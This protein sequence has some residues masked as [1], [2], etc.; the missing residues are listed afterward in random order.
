[1]IV[2]ERSPAGAC[3]RCNESGELAVGSMGSLGSARCPSVVCVVL[4]RIREGI[5]SSDHPGTS[6]GSDE[7]TDVDSAELR[8][9]IK[10]LEVEIYGPDRSDDLF[11]SEEV[12]VNLKQIV[13]FL[14][15][16]HRRRTSEMSNTQSLPL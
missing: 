9:R 13:V 4:Q 7:S 11:S 15:K 5:M 8:E 2:L 10:D 14:E 12:V 6:S 3:S 16:Q 1:M